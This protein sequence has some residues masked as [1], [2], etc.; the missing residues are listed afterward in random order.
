MEQQLKELK[1]DIAKKLISKIDFNEQIKKISMCEIFEMAKTCIIG[2]KSPQLLKKLRIGDATQYKMRWVITWLKKNYTGPPIDQR[3]QQI[4]EEIINLPP[5]IILPDLNNINHTVEEENDDETSAAK[6]ITNNPARNQQSNT[7]F[8]QPSTSAIQPST[9]AIQPA[10]II[11]TQRETPPLTH[12]PLKRQFINFNLHNENVE[13]TYDT[14]K[15]VRKTV[16]RIEDR[17]IPSQWKPWSTQLMEPLFLVQ[18]EQLKPVE[19]R[20]NIIRAMEA[21]Q[22]APILGTFIT[23][24]D[25]LRIKSPDNMTRKMNMDNLKQWLPELKI[26]KPKI[27]DPK[28]RLA[29]VFYDG[30]LT[31]LSA[32]KELVDNI[33]IAAGV[34]PDEKYS[35]EGA[36]TCNTVNHIDIIIIISP[37]IRDKFHENRGI[38]YY[39]G[40][41]I[42]IYDYFKV[43]QCSKCFSFQH[44]D[45]KCQNQQV[46]KYCSS[47]HH[48]RECPHNNNKEKMMCIN[49]INNTPEFQHQAD[50]WICP[51]YQKKLREA[52]QHINYEY[53]WIMRN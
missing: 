43:S 12:K 49:C 4:M 27:F 41:E 30:S 16:Y 3:E 31:D 46:C 13:I 38:I 22:L 35:I 18:H 42:K 53:R 6:T 7:P 48:Y 45:K 8:I 51:T 32:I 29:K 50:E 52:I 21:K 2:L 28:I 37:T 20:D 23:N 9:S 10:E 33:M 40:K 34:T 19:I 36:Y 44:K 17:P 24:N 5:S 1:T 11:I 14:A 26:L 15:K 47:L 39:M 25:A